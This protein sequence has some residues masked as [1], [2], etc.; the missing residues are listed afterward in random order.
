MHK[1]QISTANLRHEHREVAILNPK[2]LDTI[3][4]KLLNGLPY[5]VGPRTDDV[6]ATDVVV[7]NQLAT[8]YYLHTGKGPHRYGMGRVYQATRHTTKETD[9]TAT[10][11]EAA[12]PRHDR[13]SRKRKR[14]CE[15]LRCPPNRKIGRKR[16]E[17][18][19]APREAD[20]IITSGSMQG[21]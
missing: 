5:P 3:V 1:V 2:T 14:T 20:A 15:T 10:P 19:G 17:S 4:K 18:S 13:R 6:A 21:K 16:K 12:R 9:D 7:F 11:R 8:Y